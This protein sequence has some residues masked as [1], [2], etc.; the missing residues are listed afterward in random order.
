MDSYS[1]F[2]PYKLPNVDPDV[3]DIVYS[4]VWTIFTRIRRVKSPLVVGN[5]TFFIILDKK[6][7]QLLN[8]CATIIFRVAS[9]R[10]N[11]PHSSGISGDSVWC[12]KISRVTFYERRM[13][14][15]D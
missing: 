14:C 13:M 7:I 4:F 10:E 8:L 1:G 3:Y 12:S 11:D 9:V 15:L 5:M 2:G 6:Q